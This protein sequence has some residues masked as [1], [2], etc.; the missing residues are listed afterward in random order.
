MA[1]SMGIGYSPRYLISAF[2]A[3]MALPAAWS[4]DRLIRAPL[5]VLGGSALAVALVM[6]LVVG[7]SISRASALPLLAISE[8]LV[9][10]LATVPPDAIVVTGHACPAIPMIRQLAL[11]EPREGL[12]TPAWVAICPGWSWPDDL[13]ATLD[14]YRA[15]GRLIVADLRNDAWRGDEQQ[16]SRDQLYQYWSKRIQREETGIVA[17]SNAPESRSGW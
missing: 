14:K 4:L 3:A 6:P 9:Q 17:W 8:G 15:S 1:A 12:T 5:K 13:A 11:R 16:R 10:D 2:P 7:R